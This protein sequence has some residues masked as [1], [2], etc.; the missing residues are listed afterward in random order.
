VKIIS[1]LNLVLSLCL[2]KELFKQEQ[3]T[4]MLHI[5]VKLFSVFI[6]NLFTM[7]WLGVRVHFIFMFYVLLRSTYITDGKSNSKLLTTT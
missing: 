2:R 7:N 5:N 1:Y 6:K 4:L 3:R